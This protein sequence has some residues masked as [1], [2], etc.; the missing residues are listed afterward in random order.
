M[1]YRTLEVE[2]ENGHIRTAGTEELPSRAR[3]LLT[4][5]EEPPGITRTCL[6]LA[7]WW[8]KRDR[9]PPDEATALA[10]D[11]EKARQDLPVPKSA[12]D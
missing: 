4:V 12:W 9:L 11:I 6:S 3:A 7:E 8:S 1:S 5:L 10:D 2:L